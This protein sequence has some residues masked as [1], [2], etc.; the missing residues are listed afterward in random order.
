MAVVREESSTPRR[1]APLLRP[2]R[3][4]DLGAAYALD[5][6]C[7]PPGIAYSLGEL[8]SF[9]SRAS[10]HTIVAEKAGQLSG[11]LI[12]SS[13]HRQ[14]TGMAHIVTL[15]VAPASRRSGIASALMEAVEQYYR[16]SQKQGME[17]EVAVN[18]DGAQQFY[19]KRGYLAVGLIRGYYHGG[20]DAIVMRK[21]FRITSA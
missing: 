7:F 12:A 20:L 6:A 15:D 2:F 11:F 18:N 19:L 5:R 21:T 17:L 16:G 4:T 14:R 10:A 1:E 3:M 9:I 8:R 13:G